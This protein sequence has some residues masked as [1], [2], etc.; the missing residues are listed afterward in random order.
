MEEEDRQEQTRCSTSSGNSC[1]S[2]GAGAGD[3]GQEHSRD[4]RRGAAAGGACEEDE[5]EGADCDGME[6]DGLEQ[7]GDAGGRRKRR[8]RSSSCRHYRLWA[9]RADRT[10]YITGYALGGLPWGRRRWD[11]ARV[12]QLQVQ[13]QIHWA[14]L[15]LAEALEAASSGTSEA[16]GGRGAVGGATGGGEAGGGGGSRSGSAGGSGGRAGD[17]A[18][19]AALQQ[20]YLAAMRECG[21]DDKAAAVLRDLREAVHRLHEAQATARSASSQVRAFCTKAPGLAQQQDPRYAAA[22]AVAI[23]GCEQVLLGRDAALTAC[24]SLWLLL[25]NCSMQEDGGAA[26][27]AAPGS[28]GGAPGSGGGG[29]S[30]SGSSSGGGRGS[31]SCFFQCPRRT[32]KLHA[33]RR[34]RRWLATTRPGTCA[35]SSSS[36]TKGN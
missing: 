36:G 20:T 11:A 21:A 16:D 6:E 8:V 10:T 3:S 15:R 27:L 22:L 23:A 33:A 34:S 18:G 28:A 1:T 4:E 13:A 31:G 5:G 19:L 7:N 24:K 30:S 26:G 14:E 17:A 25:P 35:C 12:E 29:G 32:W 9:R 2:G